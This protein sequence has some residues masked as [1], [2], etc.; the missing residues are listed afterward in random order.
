GPRGTVRPR[1]PRQAGDRGGGLGAVG[2]PDRRAGTGTQRERE[3]FR[4]GDRG[5][6]D[7][8]EPGPDR[9]VHQARARRLRRRPA[10]V[11]IG[12]ARL[13]P[14]RKLRTGVGPRRYPHQRPDP[15]R[16]RRDPRRH[17]GPRLPALARLST[18][19]VRRHPALATLSLA[20]SAGGEGGLVTSPDPRYA[21]G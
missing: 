6:V 15:A 8:L 17:R 16:A 4:L 12:L 21:G 14:R 10:D 18:G 11:R 9:P 3:T 13:Y 7:R 20:V 2:V 19:T 1:P 5:V